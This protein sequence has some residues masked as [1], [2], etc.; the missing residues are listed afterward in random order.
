MTLTPNHTLALTPLT[1]R[2]TTQT[3]TL[4]AMRGYAQPNGRFDLII[5]KK[6]KPGALHEP[7]PLPGSYAPATIRY[8]YAYILRPGALVVVIFCDYIYCC[9]TVD[10]S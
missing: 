3:G 4:Q 7:C 2:Y 9:K 8:V 5:N 6:T 1:L 10:I